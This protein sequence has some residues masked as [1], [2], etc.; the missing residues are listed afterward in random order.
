MII[1]G[2]KY[3]FIGLSSLSNVLLVFRF[4]YIV[5]NIVFSFEN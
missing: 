4:I 1:E 3:D 5:F 2:Y